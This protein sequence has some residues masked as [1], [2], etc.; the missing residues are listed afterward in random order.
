MSV[1]IFL[2]TVSDEFRVY[3][4]Q[5]RTDL[6]RHN[7]EVKV[8]EDFRQTGDMDTVE[9]LAHYIRRCAA[10]I[11]LVGESPGAAADRQAVVDYLAA[12]PDCL[13]R[14]QTVAV[15][16][17][18]SRDEAVELLPKTCQSLGFRIP[19]LGRPRALRAEG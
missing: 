4:D 14:S 12:Q 19:L 17:V 10:V 13:E 7:V 16:T 15:A 11:H 5:L 9:K 1:N 6:T 2:S 3:R 8:Q 18:E